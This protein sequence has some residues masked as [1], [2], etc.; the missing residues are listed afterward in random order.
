MAHLFEIKYIFKFKKEK[1][2][3]IKVNGLD[4]FKIKKKWG[5]NWPITMKM[6]FI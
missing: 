3:A 5:K 4:T 6:I 2:M 1:L